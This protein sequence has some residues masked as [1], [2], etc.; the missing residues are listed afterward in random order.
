MLAPT[1]GGKTE[2]SIFPVLSG[3]LEKPTDADDHGGGL[4]HRLGQDVPAQ[5]RGQ[6]GRDLDLDRVG[7]YGHSGGGFMSTAAMLDGFETRGLDQTGLSQKAGPAAVASEAR[8]RQMKVTMMRFMDGLS[9]VG[10]QAG[11]GH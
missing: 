8:V 11:R 9:R 2:A 5:Q 4:L 7:I 1:A 3:L 10:A 6:L